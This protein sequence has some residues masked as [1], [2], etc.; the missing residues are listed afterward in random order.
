MGFLSKLFGSKP[1][2]QATDSSKDEHAVLVHIKLAAEMPSEDEMAKYHALQDQLIA[3]I[4]AAAAGELDGD[5]WGGGECVIYTYGPGAD[6]LW[7]AIAPV[8]EKHPFPRGSFAIKRYG[9]PDCGR[10]ERVRIEW[11][12]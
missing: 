9:G 1:A 12:G 4:E 10:E 3:A 2:P 6:A 11:D 5:E 8:L 7:D